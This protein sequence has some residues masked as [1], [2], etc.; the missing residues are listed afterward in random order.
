MTPETRSGTQ[1]AGW[2]REC[3][4]GFDWWQA[5]SSS[6]WGAWTMFAWAFAEAIVWPI[7]PE[8]LLVPMAA[9]N[10]RRFYVPL[11]AAIAGSA[12]GGTL[13]LLFAFWAPR[14][15]AGLLNHL[16]LTGRN[17]VP[18]A[19]EQ[20]AAHGAS[21][22]WSQP[23]SGVSFKVWAI[24]GGI[25]GMDPWRAIPIFVVAR[26]ARMAVFATVARVLAGLLTS[27][28]RDFSIFILAI[29]LVLFFFS[30]WQ[31]VG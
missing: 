15:A 13:L 25:Q 3:R 16:P 23:L 14:E 7:I 1:N 4:A 9:G 8:F 18:I 30:W 11:A 22:F 19:R 2:L 10:R 12:L 27:F 24:L 5:F 6:R 17:A 21:A 26:A 28:V 31:V 20:L 29:Y